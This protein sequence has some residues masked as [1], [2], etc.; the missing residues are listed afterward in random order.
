MKNGFTLIEILIA[1]VL[2]GLAIAALVG[3][4]ISFTQANGMGANFPLPNFSSSKSGNSLLCWQL[5]IRKQK[6]PSFG[7]EEG[8]L[9]NYD[10]LDDLDGTGSGTTFNPPISSARAVLTDLAGYSQKVTV[11][12]IDP[13]NFQQ[14]VSD[15]ST[16]FVRVT[17][18]IFYN[19]TEICSNSWIRANY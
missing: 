6:L 11:K 9:A 14:D 13:T 4:N 12:N 7:P 19:S 18:T 17:V 2:V 10:D 1:T 5:S 8:A 16:D 3:S 15:H